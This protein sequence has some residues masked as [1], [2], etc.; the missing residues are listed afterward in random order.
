MSEPGFDRADLQIDRATVDGW[1]NARLAKPKPPKPKACQFVKAPLPWLAAAATLP[2]KAIVVGLALWFLRGVK[3]Q[4]TVRLTGATLVKVG[5][6]RK[7][8]YRGLRQLENAGLV[9]VTRRRGSGPSVTILDAPGETA[10]SA[11]G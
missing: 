8:G 5:V 10:P 2:G 3:K 1:L 6:T 11:D 7:A 4:A 9:Q